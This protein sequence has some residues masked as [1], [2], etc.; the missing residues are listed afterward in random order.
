LFI[1]TSELGAPTFSHGWNVVV[2]EGGQWNESYVGT[3]IN[4][5]LLFLLPT[6]H[7]IHTPN[8]DRPQPPTSASTV[9]LQRLLIKMNLILLKQSEIQGVNSTSSSSQSENQQIVHLTSKDERAKHIANH[10]NKKSGETVSIG[11]IGG[12]K[13]KAIV[14]NQ[15]GGGIRLEI[16]SDTLY[17]PPDEPEITLLLAVPFPMRIKALWPVISSFSAVTRIVIVKGKKRRMFRSNILH[18]KFMRYICKL[19]VD[20][21]CRSIIQP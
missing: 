9:K 18:S 19:H 6:T 17:A 15:N 21:F 8:V 4:N 10:L 11:I 12:F 16:Q 13:G 5:S 20:V 3:N 1:P 14:H 7:S 2:L